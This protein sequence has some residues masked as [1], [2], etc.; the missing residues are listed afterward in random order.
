[1]GVPVCDA[2]VANA[3]TAAAACAHQEADGELHAMSLRRHCKFWPH[4]AAALNGLSDDALAPVRYT[5]DEYMRLAFSHRFCI[6]SK[7][8]YPPT[9][10]LAETIAIAGLGGCLPVI[11]HTDAHSRHLPYAN[12]IDYCRVA[13]I[14]RQD[15]AKPNMKALLDRLESVGE[16]EAMQRQAAAAAL[17][18]AF[19]VRENGATLWEPDAAHY[20]VAE[21]CAIAR[22]N[23]APHGC[24]SGPNGGG[25]G[26][27]W[28]DARITKPPQEAATEEERVWARSANGKTPATCLPPGGAARSRTI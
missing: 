23:N 13:Y 6:I 2:M 17:R 24:T 9:N 20:L 8:D 1:M 21:M 10:K 16:G 3:T 12:D 5:L 11:I 25:R 27:G 15:D 19:V 4:M 26:R 14:T 22:R 28:D 18:G 7:G